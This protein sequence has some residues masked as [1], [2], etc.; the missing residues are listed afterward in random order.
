MKELHAVIPDT[1]AVL[2][3]EPEELAGVLL[4]CLRDRVARES[5][6]IN[7]YNCIIELRSGEPYHQASG[8]PQ[9]RIKEVQAAVSEAFAW[10]EAQALLVPQ[11]EAPGDG[12]KI[13]SRRA[14]R[15][16]TKDDFRQFRMARQL[17]RDLLHPD[18]AEKI[19]LAF[20]RGDFAEA[21]FTSMRAV[22]VAVRQVGM[23]AQKQVGTKLMQAA[24]GQGG[25]LRDPDADVAEEDGL[26]HLFIGAMGSYKNPHSHRNV[27]MEDAGETIEIVMLASHLLRIVDA[28]RGLGEPR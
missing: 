22:E 1:D 8:Y 13:L 21:V 5:R 18:I 14:Q 16:E 26:M 15:L 10:L 19:W 9:Q 7:P 20:V 6:A 11:P 2:A 17:N 3:L 23:F 27:A 12:W 25:P 4:R 24:F 28:R